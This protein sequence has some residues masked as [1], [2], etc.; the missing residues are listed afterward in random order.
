MKDLIKNLVLG[1]AVLLLTSC[2]NEVELGFSREN[3]VL[4]LNSILNGEE[5]TIVVHLSYSRPLLST[6]SFEDI[7][8]AK[9]RLFENKKLIGF[10]TKSDSTIWNLPYRVL[11]GNSYKIEVICNDGK[12]WGETTIPESITAEITALNVVNYRY[13][14]L[15]SFA[16]DLSRDNYYWIT[17]KGYTQHDGN[18]HLN[19][20][21]LYS[22]YSYADDFNRDTDTGINGNY[23]YEYFNYIRIHNK[24]LPKDSIMIQFS[25]QGIDLNDGTQEVFILSTDYHLDKYMK[26][27]LQNEEIDSY[28]E[29]VPIIYAP[30]PV[31]SNIHGGTGIFGSYS[32]VS[33][34]FIKN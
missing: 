8:D 24:G 11:P 7:S 13:D 14:Y 10:F 32:C 3:S 31:Y 19:L 21:V 22:N 16:D 12:I 2:V 29:D 17:A 28:A 27:S 25:P 30:F 4:T 34:K 23:N 18:P 15:V 5:D 26:S 6:I 1:I 33:K 20:P 9:V